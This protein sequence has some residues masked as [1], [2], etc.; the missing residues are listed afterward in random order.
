MVLVEPMDTMD[1]DRLWLCPDRASD[2]FPL[3]GHC[4][5]PVRLVEDD[6]TPSDNAER[7]CPRPVFDSGGVELVLPLALACNDE[8]RRLRSDCPCCCRLPLSP[9]ATFLKVIVHLISSP[10]KMV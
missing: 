2:P 9:V 4:T 5:E 10:A 1:T 8:A 6:G 7:L 3:D